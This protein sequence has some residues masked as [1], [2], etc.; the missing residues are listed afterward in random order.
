MTGVAPGFVNPA[1][2]DYHLIA[3]SGPV[4][5][6]L[7]PTLYIDGFG[8]ACWAA[9]E[10]EYVEPM[11]SAARVQV[12][13]SQDIGAYEV[14]G[15]VP[16][17]PPPPPAGSLAAFV[18]TDTTTRGTWQ[19]VYGSQGYVLPNV[20]ASLPAGRTVT[21]SAHASWTWVAATSDTRAL[22]A[23]GGGSRIAA[24]WYSAGSFVIDV[25]PGDSE[26]HR[27][28]L[29]LLDWDNAGRAQQVEVLDGGS[30]AVLDTR[31]VNAFVGGQYAI[32]EVRGSVRIRVT[33]TAGVNAVVSAVFMDPTG[34]TP[35]PGGSATAVF[36]ATDTTTQGDWSGAY[37]TQGY[38]LAKEGISL[39][40]GATVATTATSWT[41]AG[42]TSD[43]R[44]LRKTVGLDRIAATWYGSSVPIVVDVGDGQPHRVALYVLDWDTTTRADRIEVLDTI[45][46]AVLDTQTVTAF[47]GGQYWVWTVTGSVQFRVTRTAGANAVVSAVF[48]DPASGSGPPPSSVATFRGADTT[49]QGT[50]SGVYG[51]AGCVLAQDGTSV[52]AGITVSPG[53]Y[54]NW[55]WAA[56]TS[57]PRALQKVTTGGRLAATWYGSSFTIDVGLTD[58][59]ARNVALYLVD[60]D[61]GDRQQ[62]V[63]VLDASGAVVDT[64][65]VTAFTGGQYWV[66]TVRGAVRFRVTRTAGANAV[67]SAIFLDPA[68]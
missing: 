61:L 10:W 19:G 20:G 13:A 36:T 66:W 47:H 39:P 25:Q 56:A 34:S 17:S 52:P 32:W 6:A 64:R 58:G 23:P 28:A 15:V 1:T 60:W 67:V 59:V 5:R 8:T 63:E 27:L 2:G 22:L 40:A 33:R 51:T 37:G 11:Q 12:G 49:T 30:G 46:G 16:P 44:A 3:G 18:G 29:Y 9:P 68:S 57:D 7:G 24:T 38:V 41:W 55:T 54:Q 43:P 53:G 48:I 45:S 50:W 35:P 62:T 14:P 42:A 31:T 65:T 4:D 26:S 21:P